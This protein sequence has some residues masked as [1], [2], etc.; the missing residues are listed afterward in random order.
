MNKFSY[1]DS[2]ALVK[3]YITETGSAWMKVYNDTEENVL[4]IA[5]IGRTEVAATFAGKKR[6]KHI[7][8]DG[9]TAIMDDFRKNAR[10]EY[11]ILSV[12]SARVDEAIN[13]TMR[14]KLRGYDAIHLAC[15]L[16]LHQSLDAIGL[17][18]LTFIA[19]DNDL[20]VAAEAEGL[21]TENPNHYP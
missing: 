6:G 10:D 13:L 15:A 12:T 4:A 20:L 7:S 19:A 2:S 8:A 5:D 21:Q 11:R 9:Y 18:P 1:V 3:L 14:Y 17:G 16:H